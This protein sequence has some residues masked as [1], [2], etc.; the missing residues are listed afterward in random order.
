VDE[1]RPSAK[2]QSAIHHYR[3]AK[4]QTLV[5]TAEAGVTLCVLAYKNSTHALV[6][7]KVTSVGWFNCNLLV[8]TA[9]KRWCASKGRDGYQPGLT[10]PN[11]ETK[12]RNQAYDPKC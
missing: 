5:G 4:A 8:G 10:A 9:V 3:A 12:E 6:R 1:R 11:T 7:E 2:S